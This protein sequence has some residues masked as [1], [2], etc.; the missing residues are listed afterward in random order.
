MQTRK[1]WFKFQWLGWQLRLAAEGDNKLKYLTEPPPPNPPTRSTP[2]QREAYE[3][4]Q[5]ESAGLKNVLIFSMESDLQR[6]AIK[7][8]NAYAIYTKLVSMFSQAPRVVQYEAAT[9]FFELKYKEGQKV[10]TH[11]LKM[12]EHVEILKA[13]RINIPEQLVVDRILHSLS[14]IKE[15]VQ[16]RVNYNMQNVRANLDELHKM[17]VQAERDMG[18]VEKSSTKDVLNINS[19]GK[20][21]FK[22]NASKGKVP[23]PSKGKGKAIKNSTSKPKKGNQSEDKCHY[24]NGMGHWK[25]NC[26]KYLADIKSGKITPVGNIHLNHLCYKLNFGI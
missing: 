19:K 4:Y 16:F 6:S 14:H 23:Q 15:Y 2:A 26:S 3:T 12:I 11:V 8:A 9:K 22:R 7:M 17:L 18:F 20:G 1:E 25:R 10:S 21:K 5:K 13:Q 24:C